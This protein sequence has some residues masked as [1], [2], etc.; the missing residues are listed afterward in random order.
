MSLL[1]DSY[2]KAQGILGIDAVLKEQL[3][4]VGAKSWTEMKLNE[5][6][7]LLDALRVIWNKGRE[8]K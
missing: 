6:E 2:R 1:T 3:R 7:R 5:R 8:S 4:V